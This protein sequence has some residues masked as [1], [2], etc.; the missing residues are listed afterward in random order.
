MAIANSESRNT[1]RSGAFRSARAVLCVAV[2]AVTVMAVK[3]LGSRKDEGQGDGGQASKPATATVFQQFPASGPP[4]LLQPSQADLEHEIVSQANLRQVLLEEDI[5]DVSDELVQRISADLQV[6]FRHGSSA[7]ALE[8]SITSTDSDPH[9][10]VRMV[11][12]LARQYAGRQNA[13]FASLAGESCRDARDATEA[14]GRELFEAQAQFH[15]FLERHSRE[16]GHRAGR[17]Q[18]WLTRQVS[19]PPQPLEAESDPLSGTVENP[20]WSDLARRLSALTNQRDGLLTE[21]TSLHPEV[22]AI[23]E[24]IVQCRKTLEQIPRYLPSPNVAGPPLE[25]QPDPQSLPEILPPGPVADPPPQP[26]PPSLDYEAVL[27]DLQMHKAA[28]GDAAKEYERLFLE[29]RQ[30]WLQ[31]P[32]AGIELQLARV[33]EGVQAADRAPGTMPVALI[34]ALAMAAGVGMIISGPGND[35]TLDTVQQV[36]ARLPIPVVG[37]I[38]AANPDAVEANCRR[39]NRSS[40]LASIGYGAGLLLVGVLILFTVFR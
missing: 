22:C 25:T 12:T 18:T 38:P 33:E 15:Q 35:P 31:E 29:E 2:F 37:I 30:T 40:G 28:M 39:S 17:T 10:A 16:Y 8:V 13:R 7:D 5:D 11:N 1:V 34:V 23:E 6:A 32:A 21:R 9:R 36:R 24:K 14:A 26:D 4:G 19:F 20:D 3:G 27:N